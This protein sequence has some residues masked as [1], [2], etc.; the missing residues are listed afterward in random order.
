MNKNKNPQTTH[1]SE[2]NEEINKGD[3]KIHKLKAGLH[4]IQ[5]D[6]G[7]T[8]HYGV[9]GDGVACNLLNSRK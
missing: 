7:T 9:G 6:D 3:V 4:I 2:Q 1:G 8:S 5:N